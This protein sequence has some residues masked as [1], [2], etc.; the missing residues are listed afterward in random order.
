ML[1]TSNAIYQSYLILIELSAVGAV[2]KLERSRFYYTSR[3]GLGQTGQQIQ[4]P[5]KPKMTFSRVLPHI[6]P[7]M[8]YLSSPLSGGFI[9]LQVVPRG[10]SQQLQC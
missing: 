10:V 9:P 7:Y 5:T 1:L 2:P 4:T 3:E 6:V 8:G